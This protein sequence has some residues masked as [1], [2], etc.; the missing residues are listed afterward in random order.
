VII[1]FGNPSYGG[2]TGVPYLPAFWRDIG[3]VLPPRNAYT[4]LH[5]TIYFGGNGTTQALLV[6]LA[7]LVV[8]GGALAVLDWRRSEAHVPAD[9]AEAAAVAVPIGA[10]PPGASVWSL[11]IWRKR[12]TVPF[13]R[14]MMPLVSTNQILLGF[15]LIVV[16]AVGAQI[17]ALRLRIPALILLLLFGFVA[18]AAT[19]VVDPVRLLGPAFQPLVSLAVGLILYDAGLGLNLRQ[20]T[21]HTRRTVLRLIVFG[22]SITFAIAAWASAVLFGISGDAALMLGAILVVSGPTVVRPLLD[23][24]RPMERPQRILAWEG[25]LVDPIGA[26]LGAAVYAAVAAGANVESVRP[27]GEF[28]LSIGLGLIGG[29]AGLGLL[30]L[31]LRRLGLGDVLGTSAQFA[32]VVAITAACDV[33]RDDSGL[34]AAIVMGLAV[35]NIRG[36]GVSARRPF[37]EVLIQITLGV[38]FISI[39]AT[40]SPSS[41]NHL[42]LPTLGLIAILVV[43]V[44]PLVTLLSTWRTELGWGERG[45]IAW[46]APRGIVAAATASTFGVGLAGKGT[47]GAEVILPVTFMVIVATVTVY[48]LTATPVARL[49]RVT[50]P[51]RARPL[52]VGGQLWVIDLAKALRDAG[53]DVLIWAG[54]PEERDRVHSAGLEMAEGGLLAAA[55]GQGARIEGVT[56]VFLMTGE[57]DFNAIMSTMLLDTVDGGVY[58]IAPPSS[59]HGVV[60]PYT[61]VGLLFGPELTGV[62]VRDRY[63]AGARIMTRRAA[64]GTPTGCDVLFVIDQDGRLTPATSAESPAPAQEDTVVLLSR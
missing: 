16:L 64:S 57:D 45:L 41:L 18:G 50:R 60:A 34:I 27:H 62:A 35:G 19:D 49:L 63:E 42:I 6:L 39:S 23:F 28:V 26:I 38:L 36:F 52:L 17:L 13:P 40:V 46:M 2:A 7:Y 14:R 15:G 59:E 47:Q 30:W 33:V 1:L 24:I 25:S 56:M 22:V 51:A 5:N 3:S 58:R 44:R 12:S 9:A 31:L 32:V 54:L 43:V 11:W 61:G 53:L 55:A 37:F 8:A 10:A 20:L 48:G 29:A 21:G 4:L